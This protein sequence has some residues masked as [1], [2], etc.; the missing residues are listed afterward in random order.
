MIITTSE[1]LRQHCNCKGLVVVSEHDSPE[2]H[3]Q[4]KEY[5]EL[6]KQTFASVSYLEIPGVDHFDMFE[7]CLQ[8]DFC[9]VKV[10]LT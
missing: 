7:K 10:S 1:R 3:R 9:L 5:Y 8:T 4:S 6:L 2:F